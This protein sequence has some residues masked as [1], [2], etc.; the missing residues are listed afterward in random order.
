GLL[1][2][3]LNTQIHPVSFGSVASPDKK[4]K[5]TDSSQDKSL[6]AS[7]NDT[8][9][10][11]LRKEI[12]PKTIAE[13]DTIT[14]VFD[15]NPVTPGH[16]VFF[17]KPHIKFFYETREQERD[18][19]FSLLDEVKG[20]MEQACAEHENPVPDGYNIGINDGLT[21]GQMVPHLHVHLIPRYK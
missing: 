11:I 8:F 14:S 17:P 13:R 4:D 5:K 2:P 19:L 6:P 1:M 16:A 20:R 12:R 18:D 21:A 9:C 10:R 3:V 15:V 7:G